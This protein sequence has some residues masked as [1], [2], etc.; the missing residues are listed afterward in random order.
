MAAFGVRRSRFS[1]LCSPF[2]FRFGSAFG[3]QR[4]GSRFVAAG[5]NPN[6]EARTQK[7]RTQNAEREP[8]VNTNREPRTEKRERRA[9]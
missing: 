1:V 5:Q 7:D 8:N 4:S 3:V 9:F 6:A 2:V